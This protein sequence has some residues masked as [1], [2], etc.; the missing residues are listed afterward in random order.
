MIIN[1]LIFLKKL[2]TKLIVCFRILFGNENH[3]LIIWMN[4]QALS[5]LIE[6]K[7]FDVRVSY[8]GMQPY[9]YKSLIQ[10]MSNSIDDVDM[11]CD[12][13][14]YESDALEYKKP[15]THTI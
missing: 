14:Q 12:K 4:E 10:N 15:N 13:A 8:H 9:N 2:K 1:I 7:A 6:E 11:I 5:D 3:W